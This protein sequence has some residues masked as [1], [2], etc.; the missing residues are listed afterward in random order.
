MASLRG[1]YSRGYHLFGCAAGKTFS[2]HIT[3]RA[4][5]WVK[6]QHRR[7]S[8]PYPDNSG[9]C[10]GSEIPHDRT[11]PNPLL[12]IAPR[13]SSAGTRSQ[14]IPRA[15]DPAA[16]CATSQA[17]TTRRRRITGTP[18]CPKDV[19]AARRFLIPPRVKA[20]ASRPIAD[21]EDSSAPAKN[22]APEGP[23]PKQPPWADDR[24]CVPSR[25]PKS[26]HRGFHKPVFVKAAT[27]LVAIGG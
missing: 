12:P 8:P 24:P 4:L 26:S 7:F 11:E 19:S 9:I 27:I 13:K 20:A 6:Q 10:P 2:S 23:Q 14:P 17:E 25:S 21:D 18:G 22:L 5:G 1:E 16:L 3:T 15:K